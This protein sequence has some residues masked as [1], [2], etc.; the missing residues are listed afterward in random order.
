MSHLY[1]F[2]VIENDSESF[3]FNKSYYDIENRELLGESAFFQFV[4]DN[5]FCHK[6][7]DWEKWI[8]LIYHHIKTNTTQ[9][10][11]LIY[12]IRCNKWNFS[13]W[14]NLYFILN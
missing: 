3:L 8:N 6:K 1:V 10:L 2:Q 14:F 12:L 9:I 13:C 5:Y 4:F 7:Y 11:N